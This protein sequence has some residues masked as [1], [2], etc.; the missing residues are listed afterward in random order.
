MSDLKQ[1]AKDN[2]VPIIQDGGL[3]FLLKTI[4]KINAKDILELGSA[5]GYSAISM[6]RLSDDIHIDTI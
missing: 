4:K 6:A 2:H 1:F 3:D 5:I